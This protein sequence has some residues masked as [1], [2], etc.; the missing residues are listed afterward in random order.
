[1][2]EN[3]RETF[4]F[5][6]LL[7][8]VG[9]QCSLAFLSGRRSLSGVLGFLLFVFLLARLTS[10]RGRCN[11]ELLL[12]DKHDSLVITASLARLHDG[13]DDLL[14]VDLLEQAGVLEDARP[15][16]AFV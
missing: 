2:I 15:V 8:P 3:E 13:N 1:M 4:V 6:E 11:T 9:F 5:E 10:K 7:S 14:L 16:D 12:F